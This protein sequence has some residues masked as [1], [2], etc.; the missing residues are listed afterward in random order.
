MN[1]FFEESGSL[2]SG[3]VLSEQGDSVHVEL[4]GGRRNKI[5]SR[6]VLLRFEKPSAAELLDSAQ[7]LAQ[8]IDLD[9][10]WACA[11]EQEFLFCDLALE[12]YGPASAT[13]IQQAALAIRLHDAPVYF[14]RKRRGRYQR[15]PE[16]QLQAA[17]LGIERKKKLQELQSHY[18]EQ[19]KHNS[20]PESFRSEVYTLLF[21]PDKNSIEWK[22][23]NAASSALNLQPAKLLLNCGAI[24]SVRA[25]H[26]QRFLTEFFPEGTGFPEVSLP[27]SNGHLPI[28]QA[29]A[30]SIDDVS[31]T[32]IDDAMSVQILN[33][34]TLRIGIHIA[35]PGLAI[36]PN[37]PID[38]IARARQSTVYV[39]GDKITMLPK[40]VVDAYTLNAGGLRPA[41]SLYALV[42]RKTHQLLSTETIIEQVQVAHNLHRHIVDALVTKE[43]LEDTT[44]HEKCPYLEEFRLVWPFIQHLYAQRQEA[45]INNGLKPENH[46]KTDYNFEVDGEH[47]RIIPW[48]RGTPIDTIVAELAIFANR[49]WGEMLATHDVPG[50]YRTQLNNR[51]PHTRMQTGPAP[52]EG[53]GVP[54]YAWCTSPLRR[55]V[56]LL[57]QWQLL[58]CVQHGVTA[59]LAAP[60]KH[61]DA[62]LYS[63]IANFE[64][65]YAAYAEYQAR[66]ERYWCLRWLQQEK[67][68]IMAARVLKGDAVRL[69]RLPLVLQ[70]PGLG[71]QARGTKITL[72][73]G[74]CDEFSLDVSCTHLPTAPLSTQLSTQIPEISGSAPST[75]DAA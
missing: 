51:T 73:I 42:D 27:P 53:L 22:A 65:R 50:I 10:L 14:H 75:L 6:D 8:E 41:L 20:L 45:R 26:E 55:Y 32:E 70:I 37:S 29:V 38:Q 34:E 33:E 16:A 17:L 2:K 60:F 24:P 58:M 19:L 3:T 69:E 44:P 72:K 15:A 25:L 9:F 49:I 48:Q 43:L 59:R 35:A 31:T 57:N 71:I 62:E 21:K 13:P 4:P 61:K 12:Y 68:D 47:I 66:M 67:A 1:I 23:L 40:N 5:K 63:I 30:F 18:E 56:D 64:E 52:H 7:L 46:E 39:P 11:P 28:A 74:T 54:Q 36:L